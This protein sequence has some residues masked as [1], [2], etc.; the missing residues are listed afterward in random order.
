M[1][2]QGVRGGTAATEELMSAVRAHGRTIQ[3]ASEGSEELRYLN[4]MNA[5][6]NVG[7]ETMTDILLRENP[8]K[9]EGA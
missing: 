6:A 3:I 5:N 4:H 7:G 1:L 9:I 2:N 8:T